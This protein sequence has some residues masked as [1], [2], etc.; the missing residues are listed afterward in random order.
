MKR[1]ILPWLLAGPLMVAGS[2]SAHALGSFLFSRAM[3]AERADSDLGLETA[4]R[5]SHGLATQ[6]PLLIGLVVAFAL[7]GFC[8]RLRVGRQAGEIA[9]FW[10]L[11]L[12]SFAFVAQEA[13]ERLI[14]AESFPFNPVHEPAFLAA[15]AL[16][17]PFGLI[18]FLVAR[19]L[20]R[21]ADVLRQVFSGRPD[22]AL[23]TGTIELIPIRRSERHTSVS[24]REGR[25]SRGPPVLVS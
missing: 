13:A 7:A 19:L 18:A 8:V 2:A 14:H 15:L 12:P 21:V 16:Q 6:V 10:F 11:L 9:P 22:H 17:L 4:T 24:L 3:A 5:V 23:S 1:R 25:S 20:L